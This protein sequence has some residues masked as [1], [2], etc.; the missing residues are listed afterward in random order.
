MKFLKTSV[1]GAWI[2]EPE[3][4]VDERGF[5][6]RVWDA[7]EF[8]KHGIASRFV[9]CNNS[10]SGQKGTLRGL[11]WQEEPFGEAKLVRCISGAIYDVIA[12]VRAKSGTFGKWAG[13]DLTAENRRWLYVP[14]GCAHGYLTLENNSEVLYAV[15]APY[16]PQ[17]ERG[18]RW[19]DKMFA[20][21]WPHTGG[22]TLSKK[23][24]SWP[25]FC[26]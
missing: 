1:S 15:T 3:A 10:G 16:A 11:H 6:A 17:A 26:K 22:M 12:D 20:I 21:E 25:D 13:V 8:E 9:Q 4:R 2:I 7:D 23:D 19:N 14:E 24:E 18:I 5:F